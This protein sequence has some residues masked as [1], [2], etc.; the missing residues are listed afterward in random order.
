MSTSISNA[1]AKEQSI[2]VKPKSSIKV[3]MNE[4]K[5]DV[6]LNGES[7]N[8]AIKRLID[9]I[10]SKGLSSGDLFQYVAQNSSQK[11]FDHFNSL[12]SL[13]LDGTED[14]SS[15]SEKDLAFLLE[16]SMHTMEVTGAN[17]MSCSA[18]LSVGIP[19]L[20]TGLILGLTALANSI[21]SKEVV[22][23]EYLEKKQALANDYNN[24]IADLNLEVATYEA[25]IIYYNDEIT[26]LNRRI[27]SGLYSDQ[28]VETMRQLLRDYTFKIS[29]SNALIQ[30]VL[31]DINYFTTQYPI[32]VDT[33]EATEASAYI[34]FDEK[35]MN[36]KKQ[37]ITA[38]IIGGVG[39]FFTAVGAQDC[40]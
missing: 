8:K 12:L 7:S 22:T 6:L 14:L 24:T 30:E 40:N 1:F 26:E 36:A 5:T 31:V 11:Q 25:D 21:A 17:F 19:I 33:L 16:N 35:K 18:G 23:K 38:G 9:G 2:D 39:T 10:V 4:Y 15:L 34:E 32:D 29:D 20:V 37:A 13:T 3:L 27:D 28:Q